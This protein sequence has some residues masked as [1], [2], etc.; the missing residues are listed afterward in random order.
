MRGDRYGLS[1]STFKYSGLKI[2]KTIPKRQDVIL[3]ITE[4]NN[5]PASVPQGGD[6]SLWKTAVTVSFNVQNAGGPSGHE[7]SQVY[8]GYPASAGEPPKVLRGFKRTMVKSGGSA[9]VVIELTKRDVSIW[10]VVSQAWVV[11]KGKFEVFVG[12]SSRDVKLTGSFTA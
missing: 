7:V 11:P 1:Y 6:A 12:A 9:K 10:D 3:E 2:S 4:K 8:L 5:N